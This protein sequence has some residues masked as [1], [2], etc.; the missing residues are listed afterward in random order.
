MSN[1]PDNH[2]RKRV[3]DQWGLDPFPWYEKMLHSSPVR[4]DEQEQVWDLFRY[5]DVKQALLSPSLYSSQRVEDA[6]D[7]ISLDPPRHTQLRTLIAQ[8]LPSCI[9]NK[10]RIKQIVNELLD[11]KQ[12][13]HLDIIADL[14]LPL[15]IRI[16][17]ETLG[18]P[19]EDYSLVTNWSKAFVSATGREAFISLGQYFL[20]QIEQKRTNP[21]NDFISKMLEAKAWGKQL[22]MRELAANCTMLLVAGNETTT[23]LI[24][25][26]MHC[27][28]EHP[29]VLHQL[30][31]DPT[32]IPDTLE[33]VL[34]F[35]SPVQRT[36]RIL[37]ADTTLSGQHLQAGQ[38][39][40]LWLGAANRDETQFP[41]PHL[42]DIKRSPNRHLAFGH[43][44]HF[45]MGSELSRL[46]AKI[47]LECL[48]E[49]FSEIQRD[50]SIPLQKA[51]TFFGLGLKEYQ[52]T[53][54]ARRR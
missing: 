32:L 30:E 25:N 44:I 8:T 16:I 27:L 4:Y 1:N 9:P 28:E 37:K 29:E 10:V 3:T 26:T 12:S 40:Y 22:S 52:V 36:S 11:T 50:Q 14:A 20:K 6:A 38:R 7:I 43:G 13:D 48:F 33:E 54:K 49:R 42:F 35:W 34:R 46:E 51:D 19:P 24:G 15:P 5:N 45:C 47:T 23:N 31:V 53:V 21:G 41:N 2:I 39:V 17:A 18:I